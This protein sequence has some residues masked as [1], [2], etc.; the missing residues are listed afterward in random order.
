MVL[1]RAGLADPCDYRQ[2]IA[3][4]SPRAEVF[5]AGLEL[6]G[7]HDVRDGSFHSPEA[8]CGGQALAFCG[9]GNPWAFAAN[10]RKWGVN[11]VDEVAFRDHHAYGAGELYRLE[12]QAEARGA[13]VLIT[14]EKDWMNLP[15]AWRPGM[16]LFACAA[17]LEIQNAAGFESALIQRLRAVRV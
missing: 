16:P 11:V 10:L 4:V 7:Y 15:A 8:M 5:E 3:G 9:I 12:K 17:K 1:T 2:L 6:R 14:T 13:E